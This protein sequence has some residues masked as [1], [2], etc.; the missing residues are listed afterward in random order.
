MREIKLNDAQAAAASHIYGPLLVLAG[1]GTGKTQ[2]L[3]ARI[4][5]ILT[6]T[7]ANPSNI[8][9]LT[10]TENAA[11]N[12]RQRLSS[13]IGPDAYDVHIATYHGFGSDI[14]RTYPQYFEEIDLTTGKDTRLERPIDALQRIQILTDIIGCLPYDSPLIGARHYVKNVSHTIS[15]LKRYSLTPS[16]LRDIAEDN[17]RLVAELSP[18]IGEHLSGV[19]TFPGTAE[20]SLAL[21]EPIKDLL[22]GK[23]GLAS[24]A[25]ESLG[26][27]MN[28]AID[29]NKSKPL[30]DWKNEWLHRDS[31]RLFEFTD[32]SQ[33]YRLLELAKIYQSYQEALAASQLYDFE[34]M[35][36][37]VIE[38]LKS[39]DELRFNLQEK[40][41]VHLARR[42]SG[43]KRFTVRACQRARQQPGKRKPA[44][45]LCR[46]RRRPSHLR[47]PGCTCQ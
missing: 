4:A 37:R 31:N 28:E 23:T 21:F 24:D 20:K 10:F 5:N 7:D 42:I 18:F 15:E 44:K 32:P 47:F 2:L 12:M 11:L 43:H 39:N 6:E 14:I 36:L 8:L 9:C 46:R 16:K 33:H 27:A 17:L 1:P 35:I 41:P 26:A 19:K 25:N 30:T 45:H 29:I 13:I 40:I 3:S 22:H 34:D 38:A